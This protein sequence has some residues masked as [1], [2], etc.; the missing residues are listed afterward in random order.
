M[1]NENKK[2]DEIKKILF[3]FTNTFT[4]NREKM[5]QNG[6]FN[7][8]DGTFFVFFCIIGRGLSRKF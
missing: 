7:I 4:M 2:H 3:L 1:L 8:S 5:K 6:Y